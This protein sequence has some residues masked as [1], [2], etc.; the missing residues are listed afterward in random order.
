MARNLITDHPPAQFALTICDIGAF[1][2]TEA[3]RLFEGE[4]RPSGRNDHHRQQLRRSSH[5]LAAVVKA[6]TASN[7]R[8][9]GPRFHV[10]NCARH[11]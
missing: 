3:R 2:L 9:G 6:I 11:S 1:E 7:R 8:D 5:H 10:A 4:A